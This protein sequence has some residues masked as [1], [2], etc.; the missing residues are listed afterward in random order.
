VPTGREAGGFAVRGMTV[1]AMRQHQ[2]THRLSGSPLVR[3][4]CFLY[5]SKLVLEL[6]KLMVLS[7]YCNMALDPRILSSALK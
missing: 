2:P 3:L 6:K 7:P 4:N 1:V 5:R